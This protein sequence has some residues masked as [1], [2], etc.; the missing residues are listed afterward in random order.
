M[1]IGTGSAQSISYC[2]M[3]TGLHTAHGS[4]SGSSVTRPYTHLV[5][6]A[7]GPTGGRHAPAT[8]G[9]A[10]PRV[11]ALTPALQDGDGGRSGVRRGES[12]CP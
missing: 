1:S 12:N 8:P 9:A 10:Q 5:N 4:G 11:A 3:A 2:S 6:V 7:D